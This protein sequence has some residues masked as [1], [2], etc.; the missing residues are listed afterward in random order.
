MIEILHG[1]IYQHIQNLRRYCNIVYVM[2]C[3]TYI[4][5][6]PHKQSYLGSFKGSPRV[7]LKA[8][9]SPVGVAQ[10]RFKIC[11]SQAQNCLYSGYTLAPK[12]PIVGC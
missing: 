6:R 8:F 7:P 4:I 11:T 9:E 2:A 5:N 3:R 12:Y 10:C 1:C